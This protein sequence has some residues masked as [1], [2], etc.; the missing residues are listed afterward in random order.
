MV[1]RFYGRSRTPLTEYDHMPSMGLPSQHPATCLKVINV[2][3]GLLFAPR[4]EGEPCWW[5]KNGDAITH[6]GGMTWMT[7][8]YDPA[9]RL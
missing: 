7:G 2:T 9:L 1:R 5:P 3:N 4:A 6:G 8:T